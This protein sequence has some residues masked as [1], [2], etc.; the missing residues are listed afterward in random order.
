M[1]SLSLVV[2]LMHGALLPAAPLA[3]SRLFVS[4]GS[5]SCEVDGGPERQNLHD[6]EV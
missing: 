2:Y 6:P 4:A 3:V 1:G 5:F